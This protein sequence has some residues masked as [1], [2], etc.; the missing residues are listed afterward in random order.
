MTSAAMLC[1]P[2]RISLCL[3]L[4][5]L[6][7]SASGCSNELASVNDVYVPASIEENYPIK[8]VERPM[9]VSFETQRDGLRPEDV[10]QVIGLG[11]QAAARKADPITISFA[12]GN[13]GSRK[14]SEQLAAILVRQG[15]ARP[16]L[17]LRAV[18]GKSSAVTLNFVTKVAVTKPCGDWSQNLRADQYNGVGPNFG[19][20][21]QQNIAA[22]V[23]NPEDFVRPRT[24][25]PA[26]AAAQS[27]VITAYQS[28]EWTTPTA[29]SSTSDTSSSSNANSGSN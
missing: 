15:V 1:R 17:H 4:A 20:A 16:A 8:V 23:N 2:N 24:M 12:S 13:A 11:R 22:S 18:E 28:G 25:T 19:C 14:A 21:F 7:A 3:M 10:E 27:P 5:A 9:R 6:S 26:Q 29:G